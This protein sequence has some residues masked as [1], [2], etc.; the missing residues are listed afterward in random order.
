MRFLV[1]PA[2]ISPGLASLLFLLVLCVLVPIGAVRQHR[3]LAREMVSISRLRIYASG[4]ATHALLLL[5]SWLVVLEQRIDLLPSYRPTVLHAL[6]GLAALAIGVLPF[7]KSRGDRLARERTQ[8][9]APRS[10]REFGA[11]YLLSTTA[12]I[13]EE[14]AYRGVLFVL[15]SAVTGSWW[16]AA[17]LA[18]AFFGIAHLFQGTRSAGL[19][20]LMGLRDHILVGLTGTLWIAIVVHVA[21]DIIAG[22]VIGVQARLSDGATRAVPSVPGSEAANA[23]S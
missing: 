6:L 15:L 16:V 5:L 2:V 11:F 22:T 10:A 23:V 18:S 12:G 21:H 1:D 17:L 14:L 8:L 19:A 9:I 3:L 13:A 7:L 20:A 4:V